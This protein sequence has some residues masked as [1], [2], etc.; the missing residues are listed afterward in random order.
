MIFR[1]RVKYNGV[2]YLAGQD[3]PIEEDVKPV[4]NKETAEAQ[5]QEPQKTEEEDK[6]VRKRG[7]RA[8]RD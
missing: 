2:L 6:P 4:E 3:V 5:V 1:H 7:R 8:K